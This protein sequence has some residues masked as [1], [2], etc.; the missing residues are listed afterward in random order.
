MSRSFLNSGTLIVIRTYQYLFK[1][2]IPFLLS[3]LRSGSLQVVQ[4]GS[5]I[6]GTLSMLHRHINKNLFF[7]FFFAKPSQLFAEAKINTIRHIPAQVNQ[8]EGTR[9]GI[10]SVLCAG[11]TMKEIMSFRNINKSPVYDGK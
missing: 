3:M 8:Q 7:K 4:G 9:A 10:V 11:R 5:D 6:S 1:N 2:S